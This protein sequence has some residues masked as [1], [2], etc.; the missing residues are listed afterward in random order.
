[1]EEFIILVGSA[2]SGFSVGDMIIQLIFLVFLIAIVVGT[3]LFIVKFN[4][5][6]SRL[7]EIEEKLDGLL[8][9]KEN[10]DL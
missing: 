3:I 1:M 7:N 9:D 10:K 5:R 6:N 8:S 2:I 4:K